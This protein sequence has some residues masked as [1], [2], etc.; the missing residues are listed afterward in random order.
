MV[1]AK[2]KKCGKEFPSPI[3]FDFLSFQTATI[4]NNSAQCPHCKKI[5]NI[6]KANLEFK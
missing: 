2:C 3:Q 4:G 6:S 1:V 5:T